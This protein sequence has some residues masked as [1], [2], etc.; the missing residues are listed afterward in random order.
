MCKNKTAFVCE[1][2]T[3]Q[4]KKRLQIRFMQLMQR[5]RYTF[6]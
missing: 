2:M 4:M 1:A 5:I 3:L 6:F